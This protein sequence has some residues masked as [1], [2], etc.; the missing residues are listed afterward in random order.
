MRWSCPHCGINLTV[1]DD[2]IGS[3]WSFSRC[4][5]CAGY[6]LIR[7]SEINLI[8]V[9]GAPAGEKVLPTEGH[10]QQ[11][12]SQQ[13]IQ[14]YNRLVSNPQPVMQPQPAPHYAAQVQP[15][16]PQ[17]IPAEFFQL[18]EPL[19]E[20]GPRAPVSAGGGITIRLPKLP[21]IPAIPPS[22]Q[23]KLLPIAIAAAGVTAVFSGIYFYVQG[24]ALLTRARLQ[25]SAP[26]APP[27]AAQPPQT[28]TLTES[29]Q[30]L[31]NAR[32]QA[33]QAAASQIRSA[34]SPFRINDQLNQRM[35][36]PVR[37]DREEEPELTAVTPQISSM[38]IRIPIDHAKIRSGPGLDYPVIAY[39][40][41]DQRYLI[42][43]WNDRWFKIKVQNGVAA[44][45]VA[46]SRAEGWIR[47]DL[48]Q[49]IQQ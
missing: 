35:M 39:A 26:V 45:A 9:H 43:A 28:S 13:A 25:S 31:A 38:V 15:M 6:A 7:K 27:A 5:K 34:P 33:L 19:P 32:A 4:Y 11:F 30:Q 23:A 49:L 3:G 36:A 40:K 16:P 22:L 48:V 42:T 10:E 1:A 21:S 12:L 24:Q 20:P 46:V 8:K 2:K 18:P 44:V 37:E 47:N 29:Q 17:G 14:N 41:P